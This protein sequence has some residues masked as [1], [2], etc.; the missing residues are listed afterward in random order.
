M[1]KRL[2]IVISFKVGI[3]VITGLII[4]RFIVRHRRYYGDKNR[5]YNNSRTFLNMYTSK[6]SNKHA[7][8]LVLGLM[9]LEL[10]R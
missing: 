5:F 7:I 10:V 6:K 3:Y 4:L 8:R 1:S 9:F 2:N